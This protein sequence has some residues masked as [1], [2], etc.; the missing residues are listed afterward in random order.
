[1]AEK[2][3]LDEIL[4]RFGDRIEVQGPEV[5]V[6]PLV[7]RADSDGPARVD[8]LPAFPAFDRERAGMVIFVPKQHGMFRTVQF[9]THMV[10]ENVHWGMTL[11][12]QSGED[13]LFR[14]PVG[15]WPA[16]GWEFPPL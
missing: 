16:G 7:N 12:V 14:Q 15:P 9:V 13:C 4:A 11:P 5:P 3:P 10:G 6:A 8:D 1:M 2:K